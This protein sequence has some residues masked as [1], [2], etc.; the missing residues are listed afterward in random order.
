LIVDPFMGAKNLSVGQT[1]K[2]DRVMRILEAGHDHIAIQMNS[3]GQLGEGRNRIFH[4]GA[5]VC[6]RQNNLAK[7]ARG[8]SQW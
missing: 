8:S 3:K 1:I 2:R 6:Q 7:E 4:R 5:R